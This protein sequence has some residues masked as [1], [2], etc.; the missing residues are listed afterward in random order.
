MR[1]RGREKEGME[2][3]EK[4]RDE[5]I[6]WGEKQEDEMKNQE[7]ERDEA[8]GKRGGESEGRKKVNV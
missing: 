1:R 8:R 5:Q 2:D 4:R 7:H 6:K 3:K